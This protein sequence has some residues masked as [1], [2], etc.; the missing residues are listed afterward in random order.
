MEKTIAGWGLRIALGLTLLSAVVDRFGIWGAYGSP[1]V[2]WGDWVHFVQYCAKVNSFLPAAWAG[3]LAWIATALEIVLGVGLLIGVWRRYVAYGT[4][5]LLLS[6][7]VAM[8]I[9]FGAKPP[10]SYSVFVD[11][12]AAFLLASIADER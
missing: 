4:A 3:A 11:A 2:S 10:L 6:F 1:N 5:V 12:A 8:T 7:A 9:S